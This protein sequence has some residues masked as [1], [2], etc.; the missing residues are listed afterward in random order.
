MNTKKLIIAS[1]LAVAILGFGFVASAQTTNVQALIAQLQAQ[2]AQLQVQLRALIVQQQSGQTWCY[3]FNKNLKIDDSGPEIDMLATALSKEGLFST[4]RTYPN[5][6][7][8]IASAVVQFQEKYA[9]E[10]LAPYN[11]KHGTGYVGPSTRAKLNKL[12]GCNQTQN[13][14]SIVITSPAGG[15]TW[16]VGEIH[17]ITWTS[18]GIDTVSIWVGSTTGAWSMNAH[19]VANDISASLGKYSWTIGKYDAGN[20]I[21]RILQ[22]VGKT[23]TGDTITA[24]SKSFYVNYVVA[25]TNPVVEFKN[26]G[27]SVFQT[28]R[29]PGDTGQI[30]AVQITNYSNERVA[31]N[32]L[33]IGSEGGQQ[34]YTVFGQDSYG[35]GLIVDGGDYTRTPSVGIVDAGTNAPNGYRKF[36]LDPVLYLAPASNVNSYLSSAHISLYAKVKPDNSLIGQQI[37]VQLSN[38]NGYGVNTNLPIKSDV[39]FDSWARGEI[40]I[41][42]SKV[43]P[44]VTLTSPNGGEKLVPG[45]TYNITWRSV[46][47]EGK[48]IKINTYDFFKFAY[49]LL[50]DKV[51]ASSGSYL[52]TIPTGFSTSDGYKVQLY[53]EA[54]VVADQSDNYFSIV[55]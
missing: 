24:S 47:L 20:E 23:K 49:N 1:V 38:V 13:Q 52:W 15:E 18:S 22:I 4:A 54:P 37:D 42:A 36:K 10:I 53:S 26:Y 30:L 16:K 7:E 51:P 27:D 8:Y 48:T 11:L 40:K 31:I 25:Q 43:T 33:V 5:F 45:Q 28:T 46:G 19:D 35:Y 21:P 41:V 50:A 39:N 9:S 55:K 34:P 6:D 44:S 2:I 29:M 14:P 32:E 12:Y 17:D 3:T